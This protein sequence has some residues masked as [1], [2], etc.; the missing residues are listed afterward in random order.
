MTEAKKP[1]LPNK[2]EACIPIIVLLGLMMCNYLLD[3]GQDPHIPVLLAACTACFVGKFCGQKF[4]NM[5]AA[6]IDSISQSMEALL[7]LIFVG[8]LVGSFEWCGTIPALVFYGLKMFTPVIFLPAVCILCAIVG[9][10]LGSAYTVSATLGI[11]F[12]TIG[13]T[14]GI[15]PAL[16]AGAVLS[17][18]CTGDKFSPLS[19]STNLAAASAQTGL[20]DHVRAMTMTTFPA[21]ILALLGFT[22]VAIFGEVGEYDPTMVNQLSDAIEGNFKVMNPVLLLPIL[23]IIVVAVMKLPALPG[24]LL[25]SGIGCVFAVVFQGASFSDCITMVHYGYSAETGNELADTLLNRGGMNSMLWTINVALIAI[26]FGGIY[27][28]IGAV[29]SLLGKFIK[30]VH[31]PFQMVLTTILTA[32]FCIATMCDQ[33]LGLIVPATMYKEKYDDLGLG[34]NLLSRSMEDGGTLWSPMIPWSSCGAYHSRMLGVDTLSYIPFCFTNILNPIISILT[35]WWG[36]NI[37]Y[38]DGTFTNFF[39][40]LKKGNPAAAPEEAHETAMENLAERRKNGT[41]KSLE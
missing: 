12:M 38:A 17:G 10:S 23:V 27:S 5:L 39:G 40:K 22:A 2:F 21:F 15:S 31:T 24:V 34:R 19:D 33:Y 7:I 9:L 3:W 35:A 14:M 8:C 37:L 26:G 32:M 25:V 36:G 41:Y 28:Q 18:A 4:K 11:A 29:E 13:E 1:R 16:I 20:F 30:R 6:G